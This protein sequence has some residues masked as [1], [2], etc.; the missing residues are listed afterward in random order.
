MSSHLLLP[1]LV[2]IALFSLASSSDPRT[3]YPIALYL[4]KQPHPTC[5]HCGRNPVTLAVNGDPRLGESP[6]RI[7]E[8][9][10]KLM[11]PPKVNPLDTDSGVVVVPCV[12]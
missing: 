1:N 11:G 8:P 3:G 7:C 6:S 10:W 5:Q 2:L 9:C 4:S 12:V